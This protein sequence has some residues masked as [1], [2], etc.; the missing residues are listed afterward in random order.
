M[1]C[2]LVRLAFVVVACLL[3]GFG[4]VVGAVPQFLL[5]HVLAVWGTFLTPFYA[6]F[7]SVVFPPK[8]LCLEYQPVSQSDEMEMRVA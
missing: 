2:I 3:V 8:H 4:A 6:S 1:S 7:S 5:L